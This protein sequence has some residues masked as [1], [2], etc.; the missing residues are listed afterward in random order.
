MP[1][2]PLKEHNVTNGAA[3]LDDGSRTCGDDA[4]PQS[5]QF[6][7]GSDIV[8]DGMFLEELVLQRSSTST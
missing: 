5:Y 2:K 4:A 7:M 3:T 6:L 1:E 8:R